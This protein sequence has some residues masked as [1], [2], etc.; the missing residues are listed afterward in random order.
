MAFFGYRY[1]AAF[2]GGA[3]AGIPVMGLIVMLPGYGLE[4]V[5]Y[6]QFQDLCSCGLESGT[7]ADMFSVVRVGICK[8]YEVYMY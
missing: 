4:R 6:R 3:A 5:L 1:A 2:L 7:C 8:V